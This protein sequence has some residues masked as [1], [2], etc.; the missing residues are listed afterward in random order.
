MKMTDVHA[1]LA[2]DRADAT[3]DAGNV[4]VARHEHVAVWRCLEMEPVD[5]RDTALTP[6]STI[7]EQRPSQ[8]LS[9]PSRAD[10]CA[11]C[12]RHVARCA[13]VSSCDFD[14]A[15]FSDQKC[16]D[17]VHARTHVTQQP[18]KERTRDRRRIH[19]NDLAREL[20]SDFAHGFINELCLK[21][22]ETVRQRH[23]WLDQIELLDPDRRHI[24][25]A[26]QNS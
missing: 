24:D 10:L 20:D 21:T 3:D 6:L 25:R 7:A 19:V 2:Q 4:V 17:D 16:V 14:A 11:N 1:A 26:T 12:R 13:N 23:V 9:Y 22:T 15:L 8:A 5:L 18:G